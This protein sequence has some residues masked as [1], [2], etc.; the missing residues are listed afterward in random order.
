MN[1]DL[2]IETMCTVRMRLL[3]FSL[4]NLLYGVRRGLPYVKDGMDTYIHGRY[5][6]NFCM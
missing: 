2:M 3:Y 4:L 6:Y 5:L 1:V